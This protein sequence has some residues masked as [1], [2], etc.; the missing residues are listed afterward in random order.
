MIITIDTAQPLSKT[1]VL[2][3]AHL[4][5]EHTD[6]GPRANGWVP[7]PNTPG[8][9]V[10]TA[11]TA[12]PDTDL[13]GAREA[14]AGE[15]I[16]AEPADPPKRKRRTKAEME[17][18]RRLDAE[19]EQAEQDAWEQAEAEQAE[20]TDVDTDVGRQARD[21]DD[22]P[23]AAPAADEEPSTVIERF[24]AEAV[25]RASALV[26]QGQRQKVKEALQAVGAPKVSQLPDDKLAEFLGLL[27][28]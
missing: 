12:R 11:E 6:N 13:A 27:K 7:D 26:A 5:A 20:D 19:A 22:E 16:P 3:L 24:R 18:A 23:E 8:A 25:E 28:D 14:E 1:D 9:V 2:L 21:E 4:V 10:K 15:P 17:A